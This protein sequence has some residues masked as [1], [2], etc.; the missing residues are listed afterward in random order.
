MN[1]AV[2]VDF[3]GIFMTEY[4]IEVH[5]RIKR[6]QRGAFLKPGVQRRL[7]RKPSM[8]AA[9]VFAFQPGAKTNI[10]IVEAAD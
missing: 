5:R 10:Q 6:L 4:Q 2:T 3:T 9:V 7:A 1:G 8:G